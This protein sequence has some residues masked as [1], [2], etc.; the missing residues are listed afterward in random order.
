MLGEY[1]PLQRVTRLMSGS[2]ARPVSAQF[3]VPV[4]SLG[5][6][7][8]PVSVRLKVTPSALGW[9]VQIVTPPEASPGS[10][11]DWLAPWNPS[12][13][14]LPR[15]GSLRATLPALPAPWEDMFRR[16]VVDAV[17][18]EPD[19]A[20]SLIVVGPRPAIQ[21]FA[22]RIDRGETPPRLRSL[23]APASP[24]RLLTDAQEEALRIAVLAGYYRIPRPLNL[25]ALAERMGITAASLSER[26]R[27]AE[28]RILTRY[29][30][31]DLHGPR[32][33]SG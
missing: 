15:P 26:L 8:P 13:V 6:P 17:R 24:E 18:I 22:E 2:T 23:A 28:G 9:S 1:I 25:H 5:L 4:G 10:V 27:R 29:V 14:E 7:H 21:A 32:P 20:A 16:L 3:D 19:G 12:R 31:D 11:L 30:E 33:P